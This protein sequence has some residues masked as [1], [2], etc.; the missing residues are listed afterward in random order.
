MIQ[1]LTDLKEKITELEGLVLNSN[2]EDH[3]DSE[4][5]RVEQEYQRISEYPF[6]EEEVRIIRN[7]GKRLNK[8][9][10]ELNLFGVDGE[11]DILLSGEDQE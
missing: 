8:I 1:A 5:Y 9:K 3:I 2:L 11:V 6:P 4:Y 7:L 10:K